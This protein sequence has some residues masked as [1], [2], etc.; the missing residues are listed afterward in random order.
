MPSIWSDD[1]EPQATGAAPEAVSEPNQ[2]S[3]PG[4]T[5]PGGTEASSPSSDDVDA[6]VKIPSR[7]RSRFGGGVRT[8]GDAYEVCR[9]LIEE[10]LE[11]AAAEK[12]LPNL[13][14]DGDSASR[15]AFLLLLSDAQQR[16]L[17][18]A[19]ASNQR[20]WPRLKTLIGAPPYHFLMPQDAAILNASGF[21]RG[22]I[23]MTYENSKVANSGQFG[24]GQL[25]DEHTRE[26]RV[27]PSRQDPSDLLPGGADY[28]SSATKDLVLQVKVKRHSN[29]K[30]R[31]LFNSEFRKQ[32]LFPQPGEVIVLRETNRM[33]TARG[34]KQ[35][36][37][38]PLRV[39]ALWPRGQGASTAAVLVGV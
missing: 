28:F 9:M 21:A 4:G 35:P 1:P 13:A 31:S 32:L 8:A 19:T 22:R 26:Y 33:L 12:P 30:K 11:R 3:E 15:S 24:P 16:R 29:A 25:V 20:S 6:V 38:T 36:T 34:L 7:I 37:R 14:M 10:Q 39:K 17:F 23:N 27:A 2:A 18:L 5:E